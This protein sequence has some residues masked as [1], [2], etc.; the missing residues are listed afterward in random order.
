MNDTS[1]DDLIQARFDGTASPRE[2][3]RLEAALL[4]DS[5]LRERHD[6]LAAVFAAL[7]DRTLEAP[8][9]TLTSDI[10]RAVRQTPKTERRAPR[11][12]AR[13]GF[14]WFRLALP[15]AAA[16]A[17]LVMVWVSF[18]SPAHMPEDLPALSGTI[19]SL[20][21][22]PQHI[23]I[24]HDASSLELVAHPSGAGLTTLEL[25]NGG[26]PAQAALLAARDAVELTSLSTS[27]AGTRISDPDGAGLRFELAPGAR[28]SVTSR[29]QTAGQTLRVILTSPDGTQTPASLELGPA[30]K[31]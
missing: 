2:L 28:I 1:L 5:R 18:H 21:S 31:H 4:S 8:P 29:T 13:A 14:S 23:R 25:R 7:T 10:L 26:T 20:E 3:Q 11:A 16:C 17:A 6:E 30:G 15:A 19:A 27:D 12:T 22:H 24:R 9:A